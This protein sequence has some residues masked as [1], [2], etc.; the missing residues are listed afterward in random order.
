MKITAEQLKKAR[1]CKA[2]LDLFISLGLDGVEITEELC[3]KHA[4]DFNWNWAAMRLLKRRAKRAYNEAEIP[5]WVTLG[6]ARVKASAAFDR[7]VTTGEA[8]ESARAVYDEACA[9]AFFVATQVLTKPRSDP[10]QAL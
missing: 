3:V 8:L 6:E 2:Q 1:A 5:A 4:Q 7:A 9:R 10:T